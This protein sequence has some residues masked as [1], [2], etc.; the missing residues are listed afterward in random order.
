[1]H[2]SVLRTKLQH[3]SSK[4]NNILYGIHIYLCY[5]HRLATSLPYF[6]SELLY[7]P[8]SELVN[9]RSVPLLVITLTPLSLGPTRLPERDPPA[10]TGHSEVVPS[11]TAPR[12]R[13]C[14][15]GEGSF[16]MSLCSQPEAVSTCVHKDSQD[17]LPQKNS[18]NK[19]IVT[20][21]HV[22]NDH[23]NDVDLSPP[24]AKVPKVDAE[25]RPVV[26]DQVHATNGRTRLSH[27]EYVHQTVVEQLATI[28]GE[29]ESWLLDIDLDFFSTGNPYRG[30]FTDVSTTLFVSPGS[31]IT[32]GLILFI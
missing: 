29:S 10:T 6:I 18:L 15:E 24:V 23:Q 8:E 19:T 17:D 16:E 22:G 30:P 25:I 7:A 27:G 3:S 13:N 31:I 11:T 5:L 12:V 9:V 28:I 26:D 20:P 14:H 21:L 2:P 4:Y 1:M 32:A